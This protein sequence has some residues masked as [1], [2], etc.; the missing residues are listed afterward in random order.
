MKVIT[1]G[2]VFLYMC[3]NFETLPQPG[4]E[5]RIIG[6]KDDTIL[7]CSSMKGCITI[8]MPAL[9]SNSGRFARYSIGAEVRYA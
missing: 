9:L 4:I 2:Q 5:Y 7:H 6:E 8:V 3:R 1:K